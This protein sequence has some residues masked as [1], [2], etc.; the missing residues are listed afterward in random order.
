MSKVTGIIV[1]TLIFSLILISGC[2]NKKEIKQGAKA[3]IPEKI[4]HKKLG[5]VK[6]ISPR[7]LIDSLNSGASPDLYFLEEAQPEDSEHMVKI[8]GMRMY[9]VSDMYFISE[10]LKTD[11]PIYLITLYGLNARKMG[12]E[13]ARYGFNCYYLDG[14]TYRLSEE[15]RKN[16]W[17]IVPRPDLEKKIRRTR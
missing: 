9:H 12:D 2:E 6:P 5:F 16:R 15:M 13:I 8:P 11:D 7:A 4:E 3:Q 1:F 10:T 17:S 14:G